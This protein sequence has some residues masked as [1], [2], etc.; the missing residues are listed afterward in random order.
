MEMLGFKSFPEKISV[1]FDRGITAIV[2]P[3][4]SGKSNI[5]DAVRWVLGEQSARTLRG[6]KM[7]DVIFAGTQRRRPVNY[8]QVTLVLDNSDKKIPIEYD[9]VSISRRVYR[10]GESEYTVNQNRC[11]LKD[12]QEQMCI[13]DRVCT[14][15]AKNQIN[16]L[17][18]SQTITGG[19][20]HMMM[21]VNMEN[22]IQEFHQVSDALDALGNQLG[23]QI[24]LQ[25]EDIFQSMH[26]I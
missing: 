18:I 23:L 20:F 26:R 15:L 1:E 13:R 17:D 7:E 9:E 19:Y 14:L 4:G 21:I 22:S 2:G 25:H 5:S 6:A 3:N 8:A 11:R 12:V 10:S 16:I 24:K